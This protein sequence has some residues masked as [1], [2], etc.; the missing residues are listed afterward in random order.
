MA[1]FGEKEREI[2]EKW[3]SQSAFDDKTYDDWLEEQY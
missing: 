2:Y 1:G 3:Q